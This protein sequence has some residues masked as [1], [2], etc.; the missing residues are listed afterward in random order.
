MKKNGRFAGAAVFIV[1]LVA[2]IIYHN[3][4]KPRL[5]I[6]HSYDEGYAW[7]RDINAGLRRVLKSRG[8]RYFVRWYYLD[9]KRHP[10]TEHKKSAGLVARRMIDD[11]QPDVI[12]A[13]DDDAQEY[14][15]KYYI[16]KP[17]I[18]IV[19]GGVNEEPETYGYQKA[20]N[21]T[22]ILE[23][24]PLEA[25][26]EGLLTF[27]A[28]NGKR[29]LVRS[30]FIGDTSE[31][32]VGDEKWIKSFR[33]DPVRLIGTKL[34]DTLDEWKAAV[35]QASRSA[36]YILTSNYRRIYRVRGEKELVP[37]KEMIDTTLSLSRIPVIGLN[38]FFA[39]D[40]G[41]LAIGTSPL[42]Q[43]ETAADMAVDILEKRRS[44]G[45]MPIVTST[46]A[47][48]AIRE[49]RLKKSGF[50][51]PKIYEACARAANYF[52]K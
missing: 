39:E 1:I 17:G 19:F 28:K 38:A 2:A 15:A 13:M 44:A 46:Q 27:S 51:V 42:E 41:M 11:W 36:D 29:G 23:R 3:V 20:D 43:G 47:V 10:E 52:F 30:F 49:S 35:R 45:H 8:N 6:L 18:S 33:W 12:I 21:V 40:G 31:T 5:L 37:P 22:G 7:V 16:N 9:T 25:V 26:K 34:V 24:L 48:V 14:V 32:M 4:H 50:A